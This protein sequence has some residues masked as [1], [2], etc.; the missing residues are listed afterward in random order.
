MADITRRLLA[1][2]ITVSC[3]GAAASVPVQAQI[4][5][6]LRVGEPDYYGRINV[7]G[8][9]RP[10]VYNQ[11]AILVRP[12]AWGRQAQPVYLRV[13]PGHARNWSKD[14]H[15]YNA[16]TVPV[17]FVQDEWYRDVLVPRYRYR[18]DRRRHN[19]KEHNGKEWKRSWQER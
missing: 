6:S 5:F 19:D 14:C 15:R 11:R 4:N 2:L 7:N 8:Y 12:Q 10:Y 16:C 9:P 17:Y 13:P 1:G 3:A 18:E